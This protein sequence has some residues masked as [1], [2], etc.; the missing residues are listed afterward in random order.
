MS[1]GHLLLE[2]NEIFTKIRDKW[3]W[4]RKQIEWAPTGQ[5]WDNF[6]TKI[7]NDFLQWHL[8]SLEDI[9][10]IY[11]IG[12]KVK[13]TENQQPFFLRS[14]REL[15][16][17]CKSLPPT[18]KRETAGYRELKLTGAVILEQKPLWG[19]GYRKCKDRKTQTVIDKLLE[20]ECGQVWDLKI[21]EDPNF[22]EF[23]LQEPYQ[24]LIVKMSPI[25]CPK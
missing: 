22:C 15:R 19:P 14:I 6:G 1:L 5:F 8:W 9:T 23:C 7:K 18:L 20:A 4:N 21:P 3:K 11:T 10:L 24:I 16:S 2:R 12:R 17:E 25:N 13:P